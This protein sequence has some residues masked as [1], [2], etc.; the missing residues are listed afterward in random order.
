MSRDPAR[1]RTLA[2]AGVSLAL[3]A[4]TLWAVRGRG[5]PPEQLAGGA[6]PAPAEMDSLERYLAPVPPAPPLDAY[7]QYI[8]APA[9]AAPAPRAAAPETE[10]EPEWRVSAILLSGGTPVAIINDRPVRLGDHLPDGSRVESILRDQIT[11]V[12]P[13]G[14]RHVLRL[15]SGE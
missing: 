13:S 12:A 4:L 14:R 15:E 2:S 10:P 8:P 9:A 7:E 5:T 1:A 11:L 6:L 3:V